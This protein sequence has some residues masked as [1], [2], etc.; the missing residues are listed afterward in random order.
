ME[1]GAPLSLG[2]QTEWYHGSPVRLETLAAGSTVTPVR[3]L[4]RAFSHK[5]STVSLTVRENDQGRRVVIEHNGTKDGYLFR[6][7]VADPTADL[8]QHPGSRLAEGEEM[9]TTRQLPL[10]FLESL[11]VAAEQPALNAGGFTVRAVG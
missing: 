8:R 2:P 6:V 3:A 1:R 11:P 4:A 9:L 7:V 5:P 10:E